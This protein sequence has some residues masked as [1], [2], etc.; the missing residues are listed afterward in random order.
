MLHILRMQVRR[1]CTALSKRG[2][3]ASSILSM[4]GEERR[5]RRSRA[6]TGLDTARSSHLGHLI[7]AFF[8]GGRLLQG[9][10]RHCCQR[11]AVSGMPL[12]V[13]LSLGPVCFA[14]AICGH[15]EGLHL[16]DVVVIHAPLGEDIL[17]PRAKLPIAAVVRAW[18]EYSVAILQVLCQHSDCCL[19]D[20][21]QVAEEA[22]LHIWT[23]L[24]IEAVS[25]ISWL[26]AQP[27]PQTLREENGIGIDLDGPICCLPLPNVT[28]L[29]PGLVEDSP[30]YPGARVLS[31]QLVELSEV[32]VQLRSHIAVHEWSCHVP[33]NI[34]LL[35]RENAC[36]SSGHDV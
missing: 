1:F 36:T 9:V 28:D 3:A 22:V 11:R 14:S 35:A 21:L 25:R 19:A 2:D 15:I 24:I 20:D 30:I 6:S 32:V 26:G 16:V 10:S 5:R 31:L 8:V 23:V 13:L 34:P 7:Q 12:L 4:Q 33:E 17:A 29:H 27:G 18:C